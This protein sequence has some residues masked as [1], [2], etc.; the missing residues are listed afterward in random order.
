MKLFSK[1]GTSNLMVSYWA[2]DS[3]KFTTMRKELLSSREKDKKQGKNIQHSQRNLFCLEKK[4]KKKESA[5]DNLQ[6]VVQNFMSIGGG[7]IY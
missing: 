7:I 6:L 2:R 3:Q 4:K 1:E 5:E